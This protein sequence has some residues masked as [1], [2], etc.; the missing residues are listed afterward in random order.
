MDEF[1]KILEKVNENVKGISEELLE[2]VVSVL[3]LIHI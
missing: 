3:S 2:K 1:S